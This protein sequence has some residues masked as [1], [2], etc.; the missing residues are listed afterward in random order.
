MS[1]EPVSLLDRLRPARR[2]DSRDTRLAALD[3]AQAIIEFDLHGHVLDANA[4]FLAVFGCRLDDIRGKHHRLF[5]FPDEAASPEYAAFWSTLARGDTLAGQFRRRA[6][7]GREV[8]LQASYNPVFDAAGRPVRVVKFASDIT[9]RKR[10]EIDSAG[11]LAAIDRSMAVIEFALDGTILRANANFLTTLGYSAGDVVGQ[12]HRMFVDPAERESAAYREF[13]AELAAG[14]FR[15][16]QF[17]RRARDGRDVWIEASYNPILDETGKPYKVVKFATDVTEASNR[18]ADFRGQLDAIHKVQAVIEF[19][20]DGT[21]RDANANFLAAA[22]YRREQIVGQHHSMFVA[23]AERNAP[24]YRAF[25]DKLGRGEPDSGQYRRIRSD[26]SDL[27]LQAT[28]NPI[29]DAAGRP[30]KVVKYCTDVTAQVEQA[31]ALKALVARVEDF[32]Q[33]IDVGA[34]EIAA[35]NGDLSTR[36]EQQA[37]ALEETAA[38]MEE[39]SAAIATTAGNAGTAF[40]LMNRTRGAADTGQV[41]MARVDDAMS[42]IARASRAV[43]EILAVIDAIAFQTNILALNAAVEAARAGDKGRGF[44]VVASEVRALAQRSAASAK[45]IKGNLQSSDL[46]VSAG[47]ECVRQ[48]GEAMRE[49]HASVAQATSLVGDISAATREQTLGVNQ[50]A[51]ALESMEE[52][53]QQNAALVEEI[54]ASSAQL[55]SVASGL[56]SAMTTFAGHG[57]VLAEA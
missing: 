56:Q 16:G 4:N 39:L 6:P 31:V 20:L 8:W 2:L 23:P 53:T 18:N 25:W 32:S 28:Y 43:T 11:Q 7:D 27:W 33:S 35:G 41:A 3:R 48:A 42:D 26:G 40:E 50:V 51:A 22:G 10:A 47:A 29:L 9:E 15:A 13:W 5:V 19:E 14:R 49:I 46:A 44:A 21:I 12:H 34:R 1:A 17:R 37:A 45:E 30:Y 52:V 55:E 36:T 54:A 24:A 38:T 57:A